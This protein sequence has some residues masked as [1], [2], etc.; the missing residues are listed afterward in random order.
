MAADPSLQPGPAAPGIRPEH[1]QDAA[2]CHVIAL[3]G[4]VTGIGFIVGPLVYWLIKKEHSTF[5]DEQ[6]REAI[7][8]QLTAFLVALACVPLVFLAGLGAC[9][10]RVLWIPHLILTIVATVQASSGES[11]RYPV[12]IRFM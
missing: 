7:N 9:L 1:R 11:Y 5:V 6:G 10:L 12:S 3:S 4:Y 2:I 8:F